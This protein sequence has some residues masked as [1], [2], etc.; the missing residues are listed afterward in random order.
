M[1]HG[2]T[3]GAFYNPAAHPFYLKND[4]QITI[5]M[6]NIGVYL[7]SKTDVAPEIKEATTAFGKWLG[8]THKTLVYG[9]SRCGMME[10]L[11]R[12]VKENGGRVYG[13]VPQSITDRGLTSELIDVEF[14]CA[15]LND[16]KAIM[17]RESEAF[18]ALPGGIGTL[19][20]LFTTAAAHVFGM[21]AKPLYLYNVNGFWTPLV[22]M[23]HALTEQGVMSDKIHE[24]LR[25]INTL[26]ELS[27]RLD[28]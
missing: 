19:D 8:Q 1:P 22:E 18:V 25:V 11:A 24:A 16:R 5:P 6:T 10:E 28:D 15:D 14:R 7:S 26:D 20:E 23:L 3:A 4:R 21:H 27:T 9:G 12:A 13:V 2:L 17:L